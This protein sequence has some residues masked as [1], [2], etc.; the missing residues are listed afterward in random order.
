M[1]Q[2]NQSYQQQFS[3]FLPA[4]SCRFAWRVQRQPN[5]SCLLQPLF[6][7]SDGF[8]KAPL[9]RDGQGLSR[10]AALAGAELLP[11]EEVNFSKL[12]LRW[13]HLSPPGRAGRL[14][15]L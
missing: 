3:T 10:A 14:A 9:L 2:L 15:M 8:V 12:A 1:S 11:C 5:G 4:P 7:V 6:V 13:A